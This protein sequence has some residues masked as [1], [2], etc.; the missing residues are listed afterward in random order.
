MMLHRSRGTE[1]MPSLFYA[2]KMLNEDYSPML[3]DK[4][5]GKVIEKYSSVAK[6]FE[7]ALSGVLEELYDPATP[8]KQAEDED[9]CKYCDYKKIC[10][11]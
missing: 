1:S 9:A 11:R 5:T 8:F 2:S 10:R 4:E 7:T 3:T 6:E